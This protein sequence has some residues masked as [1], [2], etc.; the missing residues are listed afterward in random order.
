MFLYLELYF[1]ACRWF[2]RSFR[3]FTILGIWF[4]GGGP[5]VETLSFHPNGRRLAVGYSRGFILIWDVNIGIE[6]MRIKENGWV[7][8]VAFSPDGQLLAACSNKDGMI[9]IWNTQ[10][11]RLLR[12]LRYPKAFFQKITFSHDGRIL[13]S[14]GSCPDSD[15][16][17]RRPAVVVL[18]EMSK[19][20]PIL[21]LKPQIIQE[22]TT[23]SFSPNG[24]FL[25]VGGDKSVRKHP[26]TVLVWKVETGQLFKSY[27]CIF[28]E[29]EEEHWECF[30]NSVAFHPNGKEI[31]ISGSNNN[32]CIWNIK[33]DKIQILKGHKRWVK[34]AVFSPNGD[35][36]ATAD[37]GGI[38]R[39][40]DVKTGK[41]QSILE[42]DAL[43]VEALAFSPKGDLLASG[44]WDG[45]V[46]LWGLKGW[47]WKRWGLRKVLEPKF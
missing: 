9:H 35:I 43:A 16:Y 6:V 4:G 46:R 18:W 17:W 1:F 47:L 13:A 11:G 8:D 26:T 7:K 19:G 22:V 15:D 34:A 29:D 30:T 44:G 42:G 14:G 25:V 37:E 2:K 5:W 41:C 31:A 32:I 38:V 45:K 21:V 40:W 33:T 20:T 10:S 24:H 28:K 36:L 23:L 27:Q 39:L 3:D 12:K